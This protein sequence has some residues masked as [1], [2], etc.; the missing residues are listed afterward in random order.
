MADIK[1]PYGTP[2]LDGQGNI[3]RAWLMWLQNP[4]V[5]TINIAGGVSV[6]TGGTGL[7]SIPTNGQLLI[8]NGTGYAL[9][10]L[11]GTGIS[12]ANTAGA[13]GLSLAPT[14]ITPGPF[15]SASTTPS[16]VVNAA[17]QF[18]SVGAI[19]IAIANTQVSGLGTMSTQNASAVAI[20]GGSV[21]CGVFG[22]NGAT[23][24]AAYVSGG[25]VS[26]TGST[27]VAPYGFTTAAQADAIITLL[28]KIRA[29]LVANGIMS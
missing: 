13:I 4:Q 5:S 23:P 14:G 9:N 8:G 1:F 7:T 18:T 21:G 12:V 11:S 28:N 2:F 17:G 6:A 19:T 10:T 3:A 24:Q 27:N 29:A 25:S 15:G 20:T 22:A 16:F 26:A